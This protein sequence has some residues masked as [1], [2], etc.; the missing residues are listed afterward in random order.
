MKIF[1][2]PGIT[3]MRKSINGLAALVEYDMNLDP[4]NGYMFLF[5][6]RKRNQIKILF[7]EKNGFWLW[8]K[9][10]EQGKFPWPKTDEESLQLS[11]QEFNWLLNGIDFFN[12]HREVKYFHAS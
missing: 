10:L 11:E 9:R 12:R 2:R 1:V 4:M 7:W 3:D 6:N 8:L 5:C